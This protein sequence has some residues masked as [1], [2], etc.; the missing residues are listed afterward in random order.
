[1]WLFKSKRGAMFALIFVVFTVSFSPSTAQPTAPEVQARLGAT[2]TPTPCVCVPYYYCNSDNIVITN[3]QGLI[4]IRQARMNPTAETLCEDYLEVC[5]RL[6][7]T[8]KDSS[9][10]GRRHSSRLEGFVPRLDKEEAVD[11]EFPWMVTIFRTKTIE[12]KNETI[13]IKVYQCQGTLITERVVLTSAQCIRESSTCEP[14]SIRAGQVD[15]M[16]TDEEFVYQERDVKE[17][18]VHKKYNPTKL[19][20]NAALLIL[21]TPVTINRRVDITCLTDET[22]VID[23]DKCLVIGWDK[24]LPPEAARTQRSQ[25]NILKRRLEPYV[26][27][28][29]CTRILRCTPLGRRFKL[30]NSSICAGGNTDK[31]FCSREVG[32]PLA[33]PLSSDPAQYVQV[34]I[35]SW[36]V[37]SGNFYT[38][39]IFTSV[40]KIRGWIDNQIAKLH[41]DTSVYR[42]TRP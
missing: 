9:K 8:S 15:T 6:P 4:D 38:P 3:G 26:S 24:F 35:A 28:S 42:A 18:I 5:C 10:C 12:R 7:E 41:L 27:R 23:K 33:C 16:L 29:D 21:Q 2:E 32:S 19:S 31:N 39:S 37:S 36:C 25:V 1:M 20:N 11:G 14:L 30:D 34:G 22:D 17:V 13:Q 40:L